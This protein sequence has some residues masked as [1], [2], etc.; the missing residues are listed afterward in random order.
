VLNLKLIPP[1]HNTPS[2][3]CLS[4]Y[5]LAGKY[6]LRLLKH[7]GVIRSGISFR[8][9]VA[10]VVRRLLACDWCS[11]CTSTLLQ[12]R[13]LFFGQRSLFPSSASA[14][15][16]SRVFDRVPAFA[17]SSMF[18]T[19]NCD[20]DRRS[21]SVALGVVRYLLVCLPVFPC[22]PLAQVWYIDVRA[23]VLPI[24]VSFRRVCIP[25]SL[26]VHSSSVG[27]LLTT[28]PVVSD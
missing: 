26:F 4:P 3:F 15:P 23:L 22:T 27:L 19:S 20:C 24:R 6:T 14:I 8:H 18:P 12:D 2:G 28:V 9:P 13:V 11:I 5:F 21:C 1:S 17:T 7:R 10:T 25:R 16:A